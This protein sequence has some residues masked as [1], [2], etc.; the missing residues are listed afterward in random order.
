MRDKI[1]ISLTRRQFLR[2]LILGGVAISSGYAWKVLHTSTSSSALS[3]FTIDL[4]TVENGN[5]TFDI[6]FALSKIITARALL[7]KAAAQKI[8]A[9]FIHE[10]WAKEHIIDCYKKLLIL[11]DRAQLMYPPYTT[12]IRNQLNASEKWFISHLLTT[13]YTGIY[14]HESA[15]TQRILYQQALMFDALS[16]TYPIPLV[17]AIGYGGWATP[18][19]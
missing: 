19:K 6:F 7:D 15:P 2:A 11:L 9:V 8:Y 14:Y 16:Q 4:P 13:W 10:P 17:E 18:P 1:N 12:H 5:V 3:N